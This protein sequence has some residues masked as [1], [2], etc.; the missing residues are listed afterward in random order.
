MVSAHIHDVQKY[1]ITRPARRHVQVGWK[2]QDLDCVSTA[3][4]AEK[5]HHV[6]DWQ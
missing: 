5:P 6:S 4:A 1:P 3:M 2:T